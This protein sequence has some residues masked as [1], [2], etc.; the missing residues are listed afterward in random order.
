MRYTR[1]FFMTFI[2]VPFAIL[3]IP[4]AL[5]GGL[6]CLIV[7]PFKVCRVLCSLAC[8][9]CSTPSCPKWKSALRSVRDAPSHLGAA[10]DLEMLCGQLL[11]NLLLEGGE[12]LFLLA[13]RNGAHLL[14]VCGCIPHKL[15]VCVC[16]CVYVCVCVCV[17]VFVF[18]YVRICV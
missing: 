4:Y 6:L 2:Y 13:P 1:N 16:V 9:V 5:L 8:S 17:R 18:V 7:W 14:S 15:F 12:E 3:L 11:R 10:I